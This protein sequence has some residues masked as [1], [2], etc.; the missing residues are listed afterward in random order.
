MLFPNKIKIYIKSTIIRKR[1]KSTRRERV[2]ENLSFSKRG[3]D[4][5][6]FD[7]NNDYIINENDDINNN[8]F[9]ILNSKQ[10]NM[11]FLII[12][13]LEKIVKK[14]LMDS[15]MYFIKN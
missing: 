10:Y 4:D 7:K 1:V 11:V 2:Q 5:I 15:L 8:P 9:K 14:V 13:K 3:S 6:L 12:H